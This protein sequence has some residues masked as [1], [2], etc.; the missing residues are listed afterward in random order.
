[1]FVFFQ[2]PK[3]MKQNRFDELQEI[4]NKEVE[5]QPRNKRKKIELK[6]KS[7]SFYE[8][9]AEGCYNEEEELNLDGD[10]EDTQ[11]NDVELEKMKELARK[12][13][14]KME[15]EKKD[16]ENRLSHSETEIH[17]D[18]EIKEEPT[19]DPC[20]NSKVKDRVQMV[21]SEPIIKQE[22]DSDNDSFETLKENG[23]ENESVF[24]NT[25]DGGYFDMS[26]K[27]VKIEIKTEFPYDLPQPDVEIVSHD[28][29]DISP[30]V[31][32]S[33]S[34][35]KAEEA[36]KWRKNGKLWSIPKKKKTVSSPEN[37]YLEATQSYLKDQ[38]SK[39]TSQ[40]KHTSDRNNSIDNIEPENSSIN[41][42]ATE[43]RDEKKKKQKR[44]KE[45]KKKN[46][47]FE[48]QRIPNLVKHCP[49]QIKPLSKE[50][51][52]EESKPEKVD[53]KQDDFVLREL[54]KKTGIQG[55]MKHDKIMDSGRPDYA[56]VEAEA[57]RVA[58]EAAAALKRSRQHCASALSGVPT[59]TGQHGQTVSKPRF[60]QKKNSS[61]A[62]KVEKGESSAM[63]HKTSDSDIDENKKRKE[64]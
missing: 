18:I 22:P 8:G 9:K 29:E 53:T 54:F 12:L 62:S 11:I 24:V 23:M 44:K 7:T 34:S 35:V 4:K 59:W 38:V 52:D 30:V 45:K 28:E 6:T 3:K 40:K 61:L 19:E 51:K 64:R 56:I 42:N 31:K 14:R 2:V 49:L 21:Q 39:D 27:Q 50:Q 55:A 37:D 15:A 5:N 46:A 58:K 16:K 48:G 57:D 41:K 33:V 20:L 1:M 25:K 63:G 43:L 60:G 47:R 26:D 32:D 17:L 13:S 10:T 36:K